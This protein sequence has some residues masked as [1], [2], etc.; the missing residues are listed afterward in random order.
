MRFKCFCSAVLRPRALLGSVPCASVSVSVPPALSARWEGNIHAKL[1]ILRR[2]IPGPRESGR[3]RQNRLRRAQQRMGTRRAAIQHLQRSAREFGFL[4]LQ[5]SGSHTGHENHKY[6]LMLR[7]SVGRKLYQ[8]RGIVNAQG[9]GRVDYLITGLR[10]CTG[11][12]RCSLG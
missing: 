11:R 10:R 3:G 4:R 8:K 1:S 2:S 6:C 7:V 5:K 9:T 12:S